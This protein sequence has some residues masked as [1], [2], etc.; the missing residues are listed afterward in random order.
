M[1]K[2]I[3][4]IS[5]R[6]FKF[7]EGLKRILAKEAEEK[8]PVIA[9]IAPEKIVIQVGDIAHSPEIIDAANWTYSTYAEPSDEWERQI[10]KPN[11]I[12]K[13][14]SYKKK[15]SQAKNWDKW[16]RKGVN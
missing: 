15:K 13:K 9:P 7:A 11:R 14:M 16:K 12:N 5:N 1:K 6:F 3:A 10:R 8:A 2:A 4:T